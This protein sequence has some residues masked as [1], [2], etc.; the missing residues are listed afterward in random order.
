LTPCGRNQAEQDQQ[1]H[2]YAT[3]TGGGTRIANHTK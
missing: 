1:A 3:P 2:E